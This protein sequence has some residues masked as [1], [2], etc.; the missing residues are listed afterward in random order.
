MPIPVE[1]R[2]PVPRICVWRDRE[3]VP[4]SPGA[5]ILSSALSPWQG[6][7][8]ERHTH[9]PH[10]VDT[11]QHLSHFLC[12]HLNGPS[13]LTWRSNGKTGSKT[14]APGAISLASRGAED[15]A[16][17]PQGARRIFLSLE[18]YIFQRALPEGNPGEDVELVDQWGIEDRKIE[19][20]LRAL[21]ADVE[22]GTPAGGLFGE[23]LLNALAIHLLRRYGVKPIQD[24]KAR[25]GLPRAR[26]NRVL[27]F[28]ESHL[29]KEITL[30]ALAEVAGMGPHYFSE[31]F[32][33]SLGIS[34]HQY[35]L[36]RRIDC[37]KKLLH[38]PSV[39]VLEAAV[40]SG[41]SDQSHFT[42]LFR[43]MVGVTPTKYRAIL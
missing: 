1:S 5:P 24:A 8:L 3:C 42:K 11:H 38:N 37:G 22:A 41:F 32:K 6:A 4:L 35:V 27:E 7:L 29:D 36:R 43:R 33:Q 34:P 20:V 31:L 26:V 2:G 18:P 16:W 23:C 17:F 28:V 12:L 15:S 21:E 9:G 13:P 14:I 19:Y 40:R 39:S 10:N 30:A 25:N